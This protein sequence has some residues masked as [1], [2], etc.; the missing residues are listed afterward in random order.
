MS[1]QA[2]KDDFPKGIGAA[3]RVAPL[4]GLVTLAGVIAGPMGSLASAVPVFKPIAETLRKLTA[5]TL[6]EVV[7]HIPPSQLGR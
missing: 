7:R 2:F 4:V 5:D 1:W 3:A 6:K